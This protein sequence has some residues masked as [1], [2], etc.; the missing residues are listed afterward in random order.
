[1][2]HPLGC[3]INAPPEGGAYGCPLGH[4]LEP[5]A[6][7][8]DERQKKKEVATY[9]GCPMGTHMHAPQGHALMGWVPYP[10]HM[11]PHFV[12]PITPFGLQK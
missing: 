11:G 6:R 4:P 8:A 5:G 9:N 1:M 7:R 3:P 12:G 10:A 2:G